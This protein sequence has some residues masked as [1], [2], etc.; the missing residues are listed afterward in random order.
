MD[1]G[2][3]KKKESYRCLLRDFSGVIGVNIVNE[4]L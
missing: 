1:R 3:E 4:E 2:G